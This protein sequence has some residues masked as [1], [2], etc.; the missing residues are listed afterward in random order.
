MVFVILPNNKRKKGI[1]G[2]SKVIII[3]SA[4]GYVEDVISD[5]NV[6]VTILDKDVGSVND[7]DN[8]L[9]LDYNDTA[10]KCTVDQ[11]TVEEKASAVEDL[12]EQI[13]EV[14]GKNKYRNYYK[15]SECKKGWEDL[16][17]GTQNDKCPSCN[18]ETEPY[19][20]EDI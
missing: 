17:P 20:S 9:S 14:D 10:I 3:M 13:D 5:S 16:S 6:Q 8:V 15:C 1:M 18:C 2:Q 12:L 4:T 11:P 7:P 19:K